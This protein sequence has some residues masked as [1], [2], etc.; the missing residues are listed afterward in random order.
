MAKA[1]E[2][3]LKNKGRLG[4]VYD[5]MESAVAMRH[6]VGDMTKESA[7]LLTSRGTISRSDGI[8]WSYDPRLK[9][10]SPRLFSEEQVHCYLKSIKAPT[11]L[12]KGEDS[13]FVDI[14]ELTKR[15]K[16]VSN[17]KVVT[18]TGGHHLHMDHP[19][20]V[21]KIIREFKDTL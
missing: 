4:P 9:L 11:L 5:S 19:F 18:S 20:E 16:F 17:L 10:P 7:S 1:V 14:K 15:Q 8:Q 21:A 12:I 3:W 13:P 6:K 2:V